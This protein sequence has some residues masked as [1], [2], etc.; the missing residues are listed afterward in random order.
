MATLLARV[1]SDARVR[2]LADST[3]EQYRHAADRLADILRDFHPAQVRPQHV[4]RIMDEYRS[5]PNAANRMRTVLKLALDL[6]V[7]TGITE[8]NP[9]PF[10]KPYR[11]AKRSRYL[12]DSEYQAIWNAAPDPLRSIIDLCYLTA[13]RI[14][15]V[16]AIQVR[17]CT[18]DGILIRQRKTGRPLC[19]AWT[20]ELREV[21]AS[22]K[23]AQPQRTVVRLDAPGY[24][25]AQRNGRIRS[26]RGV[27]DLWDRACRRAGI[28]DRQWPWFWTRSKTQQ[29]SH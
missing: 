27:R 19:I 7:R 9:V 17:D 11:E 18:E 1:V 22:A 14:G 29:L 13:Q 10:I 24:L 23:A 2:G 12:T 20:R 3:I 21:V 8:S 25:L 28:D 5:T 16:L 26:Y 6:A 15:D 4:A